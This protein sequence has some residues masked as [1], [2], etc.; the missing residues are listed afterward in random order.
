M[1]FTDILGNAG[2]GEFEY[3]GLNGPESGGQSA[4]DE[5][6]MFGMNS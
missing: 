6:Q 4:V 3:G 5:L 2:L 1:D